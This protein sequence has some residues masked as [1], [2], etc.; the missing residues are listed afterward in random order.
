MPKLCL[1]Q[2]RIIGQLSSHDMYKR[3]VLADDSEIQIEK[4]VGY[5]DLISQELHNANIRTTGGNKKTKPKRLKWKIIPSKQENHSFLQSRVLFSG[6][7]ILNLFRQQQQQVSMKES[8][9][10]CMIMKQSV[11]LSVQWLLML[12]NSGF[13]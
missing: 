5:T 7:T 11:F 4:S 13:V 3:T 10:F 12:R 1:A 6:N 9:F 8:S 2:Y